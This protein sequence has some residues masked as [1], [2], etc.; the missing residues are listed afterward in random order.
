MFQGN[1]QKFEFHRDGICGAGPWEI[2]KRGSGGW[3]LQQPG[4]QQ[5]WREWGENVEE[6][7]REFV[8]GLISEGKAAG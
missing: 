6:D 4:V 7:F 8:D 5:S 1:S 3:L 2:A